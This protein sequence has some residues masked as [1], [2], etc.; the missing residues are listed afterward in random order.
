MPVL[1][2]GA[3]GPLLNCSLTGRASQQINILRGLDSFDTLAAM[4]KGDRHYRRCSAE[5]PCGIWVRYATPPVPTFKNPGPWLEG[6]GGRLFGPHLAD[7]RAPAPGDLL[8]VASV[9]KRAPVVPD[10]PFGN[11]LKEVGDGDGGHPGERR[12]PRTCIFGS[13]GGWRAPAVDRPG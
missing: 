12:R 9:A 8:S 10:V 1:S 11:H 13:R 5:R 7:N 3:L 4:I 6:G 2:C